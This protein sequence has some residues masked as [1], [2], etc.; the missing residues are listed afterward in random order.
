MVK[1]TIKLYL[2][3]FF[4]ISWYIGTFGWDT[5][6]NIYN[7]EIQFKIFNENSLFL[8]IGNRSNDNPSE[9]QRI[10]YFYS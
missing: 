10:N 9:N 6:Y 2:S 1:T 5:I 4:S 3:H 8:W 7:I